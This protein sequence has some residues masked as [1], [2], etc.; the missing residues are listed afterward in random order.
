LFRLTNWHLS[1]TDW[2]IALFGLTVARLLMVLLIL[3]D[4]P[5]LE[6]HWGTW[7]FFYSGDITLYTEMA[8][9]LTL[10]AVVKNVSVGMGWPWMLAGIMRFL[11]VTDYFGAVPGIVIVCAVWL[12]V[13]SVPIFGALGRLL[14][15][16]RWQ[17][18]WAAALWAL[19]PYLLWLGFGVHP[20]AEQLRDAYVGRQLWL[21]PITDGPAMF[22]ALL[23]WALALTSRQRSSLGSSL[24]M[25]SGGIA[26]GFGIAVRI[27]MASVAVPIFLGLL[28]TRQWRNLSLFGLGLLIGYGPQFWYSAVADCSP[29]NLPYI[30]EWL[31]FNC[32]GR[33]HLTLD[34]AHFSTGSLLKSVSALLRRLP[35]IVI[36][37]GVVGL[38]GLYAFAQSWRQKGATIAISMF[39]APALNYAIHV[40]TYVYVTDPVRF[41]LPAVSLGL[42]ALVWTGTV[43]LKKLLSSRKVLKS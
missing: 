21:S 1:Q 25:L 20:M 3:N 24:Y 29:F 41:T 16:S 7:H 43:M 17:G 28:V 11:N 36:A 8:Y 26:L 5:R 6:S 30:R 2:A 13:L 15:G 27:H 40:A 33:L 37:A 10:G 32:A 9:K 35:V 19:F 38:L 23:G 22:F 12:G 34:T 39:G 31:S 14:T 4:L 18:L 42:P